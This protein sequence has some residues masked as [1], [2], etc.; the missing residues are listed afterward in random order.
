M[1]KQDFMKDLQRIYD[2]LQ[3]R[4]AELNSYY[5]LLDKNKGHEKAEKLI[6]F[7]LM[8]LN[9]PRDDEGY[10]AGLTRLVGLREDALEQVMQKNGFDKKKIQKK[11][12][13]AYGF[14]N[15]FHTQR[16]ESLLQW[17]EE[18]QLLTP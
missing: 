11:K 13:V 16:H 14:V 8:M 7:F 2:E 6:K 1:K 3:K 5:D 9:I 18:E 12:E 10:M 15:D 4:Q 17:I